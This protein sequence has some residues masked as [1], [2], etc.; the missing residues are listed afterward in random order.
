[1][2][3]GENSKLCR[4]KLVI[5][6]L[7]RREFAYILLLSKNHRIFAKIAKNIILGR[8]NSFLTFQK[9]L[10][11]TPDFFTRKPKLALVLKSDSHSENASISPLCNPWP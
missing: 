1:M 11:M 5:S 10:K 8:T 4:H 3:S 2:I 7:V 6:T 9:K